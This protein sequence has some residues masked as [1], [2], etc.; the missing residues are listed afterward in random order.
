MIYH[1]R[2]YL[3]KI[4]PSVRFRT[5]CGMRVYMRTL[6]YTHKR[7]IRA[8]PHRR[9]V[10]PYVRTYIHDRIARAHGYMR[11]WARKHKHAPA[12]ACPRVYIGVY[13]DLTLLYS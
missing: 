1:V 5:R 3:P 10:H 11:E 13:V 9:F 7:I 12:M 4:R 6:V 8:R 2:A